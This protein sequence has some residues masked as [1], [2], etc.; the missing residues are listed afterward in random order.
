[1]E[2]DKYSFTTSLEDN[3]LPRVIEEA[4][5]DR[6]VIIV[7]ESVTV[8][9]AESD[10][11]SRAF[12]LV[13]EDI[14]NNLGDIVPNE[15]LGPYALGDFLLQSFKSS[16]GYYCLKVEGTKAHVDRK[17]EAIRNDI[18]RLY[19]VATGRVVRV[20]VESL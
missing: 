16:L 20:T 9:P 17:V 3:Y 12:V 2:L 11:H 7:R 19:N 6:G 13:R 1:M 14:I 8:T 18:N 4:D 10:A 15:R 5:K